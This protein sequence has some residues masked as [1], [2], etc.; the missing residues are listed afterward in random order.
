MLKILN[1]E[2]E[3]SFCAI[4]PKEAFIFGAFLYIKLQD[5]STKN[6]VVIDASEDASPYHRGIQTLA[7]SARVIPVV[8]ETVTV[9]KV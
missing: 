9:R 1:R 4:R 3:V 6:A 8:I 7:Y 2:E 5:T